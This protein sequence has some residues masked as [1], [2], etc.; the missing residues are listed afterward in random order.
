[1]TYHGHNVNVDWYLKASLNTQE[2]FHPQTHAEEDFLLLDRDRPAVPMAEPLPEAE[3]NQSKTDALRPWLLALAPAM[4]VLLLVLLVLMFINFI[5]NGISTCLMPGILLILIIAWFARR[6]I[7]NFVMLRNIE[8]KEAQVDPL[9]LYPGDQARCHLQFQAKTSI[10]L[11]HIAAVVRA[12]ERSTSGWGTREST[13]KHTVYSKQ[14]LKS[15]GEKLA[16][17]RWITFDCC[18]SIPANAHPTFNV[19][20]NSLAWFIDLKI[21]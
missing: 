2:F 5:P 11:D 7:I 12:V 17:G 9:T 4:A 20:D 18:V 13:V 21:V 14:T 19:K 1:L 16:V 15:Y 10:Y 3:P 8:I 6:E